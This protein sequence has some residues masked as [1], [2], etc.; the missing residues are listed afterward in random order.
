MVYL[1]IRC[2]FLDTLLSILG[3][4]LEPISTWAK[5]RIDAIRIG[6]FR[7]RTIVPPLDES[8]ARQVVYAA[9][10]RPV[11]KVISYMNID[12]RTIY[13][14]AI[15][16][17]SDWNRAIILKQTGNSYTTVWKSEG[18]EIGEVRDLEITDCDNDGVHEIVFEGGSSGTGAFTN[19]LCVYVHKFNQHFTISETVNF[20][21][22]CGPILPQTAV[23]PTPPELIRP[24]LE[25]YAES[26]GYFRTSPVIDWE[27][28]RNAVKRWH[29]DNGATPSGKV[30][31]T[32]YSG[33]PPDELQ[34]KRILDEL[35]HSRKS[36]LLE[37]VSKDYP[38]IS[39]IVSTLDDGKIKWIAYFKNPLVGYVKARGEWFIAFSPSWKYNWVTS[40]AH[41]G[42]RLWFTV[43]SEV[44]IYSF[45]LSRRELLRHQSINGHNF[46]IMD[47]S[48]EFRHGKLIINENTSISLEAL[49]RA[50]GDREAARKLS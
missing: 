27:S 31:L 39:T 17:S 36:E 33:T 44:C 21:D 35:T 37:S 11:E 50:C 1:N 3:L 19:S 46:D 14:A 16:H 41:D 28:P 26:K 7:K 12:S 40:V 6:R 32:F 24:Q 2:E 15:Y 29:R 4:F 42:K 22:F 48:L 9:C 10:A 47:S 45:D 43:H 25:Q 38:F 30:T 18:I 20:Q 34:Q 49:D 5:R 23:E 13:I 8:T